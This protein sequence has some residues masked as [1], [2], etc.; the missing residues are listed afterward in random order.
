MPL[1]FTIN[2]QKWASRHDTGKHSSAVLRN[3]NF[4]IYIA[5]AQA[6]RFQLK[7]KEGKK[8]KE[9]LLSLCLFCAGCSSVFF[10]LDLSVDGTNFMQ[11]SFVF[12]RFSFFALL[13][14][15][16]CVCQPVFL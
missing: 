12:T 4:A 3:S 5:I 14:V 2:G 15:C 11:V 7:K 16:A 1:F 10:V 8:E 6:T 13:C 9:K